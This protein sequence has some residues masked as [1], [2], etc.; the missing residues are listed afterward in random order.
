M[1]VKYIITQT[2]LNNN[3]T[4]GVHVD[5]TGSIYMVKVDNSFRFDDISIAQNVQSI[6]ESVNGIMNKDFQYKIQKETREDVVD[7]TNNE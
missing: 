4:L 1:E 2:N 3:Q 6:L 5:T 7:G